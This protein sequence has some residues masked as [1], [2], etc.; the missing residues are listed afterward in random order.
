MS[1]VR[2]PKHTKNIKMNYLQTFGNIQQI[3]PSISEHMLK[4]L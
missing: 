4:S 1:L 2:F 3:T